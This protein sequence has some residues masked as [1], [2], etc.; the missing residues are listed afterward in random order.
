VRRIAAHHGD[1]HERVIDGASRARIDDVAVD[2][3]AVLE[4]MPVGTARDDRGRAAR[5]QRQRAQRGAFRAGAL[6][7]H[8]PAAPVRAP[9]ASEQLAPD[10]HEIVRKV[11]PLRHRGKPADRVALTDARHVDRDVARELADV[12][13]VDDRDLVEADAGAHGL[14]L[15]VRGY[16]RRV[17]VEAPKPYQRTHGRV[18]AAG[19][20]AMHVGG[21]S[22]QRDELRGNLLRLGRARGVESLESRVRAI[23]RQQ[24]VDAC[25]LVRNRPAQRGRI[26]VAL[27][28]PLDGVGRALREARKRLELACA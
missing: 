22:Q 8:A 13:G 21:E 4:E 14:E 24:L 3:A 20:R 23:V 2:L 17:A 15:V 25:E 12:I 9:A 19:A 11:E 6:D 26:D 27:T 10:L 1:G 18:E 28:P 16:A 5:G 7:A